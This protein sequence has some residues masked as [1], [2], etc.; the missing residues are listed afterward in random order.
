M[1]YLTEQEQLERFE[2]Y[3]LQLEE[4]LLEGESFE[5]IGDQ[6][7]FGLQLSDPT[8]FRLRKANKKITEYSGFSKEEVYEKWDEYIKIVHP[9]TIKSILQFLPAF[10]ATGR[11]QQTL[12]FVQ[13]VKTF[14][15]SDF[16][17]YISFT[18][19]SRL[20]SGLLLWL[21]VNPSQFGK[22][23]RKIERIIRMD[24]FK[25][26]HFKRFQQLTDREVDVLK[27]LANG[28]NN[29]AI[30]EKLYLSRS[31]VETH[32]KNIKKKL[33]L[34]SYKDLIKYAFAFNLVEI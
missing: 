27:L 31:T 24:E 12:A 25:L 28:H 6:I 3:T 8:D 17:P 29:P 19:P 34:N 20:S 21:T 16:S 10:Y 7:P 23:T 14:Q 18:K 11:A 1:A 33:E 2:Y 22:E 9:S 15:E 30:A 4:R 26:K 32:R 13:Y 5:T